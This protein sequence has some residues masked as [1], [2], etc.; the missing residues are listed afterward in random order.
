MIPAYRCLDTTS[1]ISN[2]TTSDITHKVNSD[3]ISGHRVVIPVI[4]SYPVHQYETAKK[5]ARDRQ[6][7]NPF[8]LPAG[9][10]VS[11]ALTGQ[12]RE[13]TGIFEAKESDITA[14]EALKKKHTKYAKIKCGQ[15]T[16]QPASCHYVNGPIKL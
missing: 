9:S 11:S 6:K 14:Y 2:I 4:K 8:L 12:E 10:K 3:T 15:I 5:T 13:Y 1:T 7:R 16:L